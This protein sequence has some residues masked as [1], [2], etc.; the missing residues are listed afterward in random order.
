MELLSIAAVKLSVT[1]QTLT[2]I[3]VPENVSQFCCRNPR[4]GEKL[5]TIL[6]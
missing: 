5:A 4:Q 2:S 6:G 1:E 3:P